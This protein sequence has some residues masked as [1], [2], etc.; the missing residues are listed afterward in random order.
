MKKYFI[1]L[2][3]VTFLMS[4]GKVEKPTVVTLDVMQISVT[5][6]MCSGN[7]ESDG[8]AE[9]TAKGVCWAKTQNPT[10]ENDKTNAGT[11][12][13]E[14]VSEITGLEENGTYFVRAYATNEAGTSYG[15]E[16]SFTTLGIDNEEPE[17]PETPEEPEDPETPEEPETPETPETPEEPEEPETPETPTPIVPEEPE[18]NINGYSYVDLG[19]PSGLKWATRNVGANGPIETGEY[20]AWGEVKSKLTFTMENSSTYYVSMDDISGD[21]NY[22]VAAYAWGST[23]RMPTEAEFVELKNNCTFEWVM[24]DIYNQGCIVTGPNGNQMYLP[25]GG[26][27]TNESIDFAESEAAY[28]TSTPDTF[29][30]DTGYATFF[31]AYNNNFCNRGWM[32]RYAG[33][34]VRPVTE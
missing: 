26:F 14:F 11:G 27:K 9:V 2:A 25:S 30:G 1:L 34:L 28:W 20:F 24:L 19:L 32:S 12:V 23:W 10:I 18:D 7:V 16:K 15:E 8:G 17:T 33:M 6:A 22:D 4:C 3:V 21:V 5:S 31:Y 29:N 13:G